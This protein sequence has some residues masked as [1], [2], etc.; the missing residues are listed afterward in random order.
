MRS[1][2]GDNVGVSKVVVSAIIGGSWGI[3]SV[4]SGMP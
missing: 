1:A 2:A 4:V 3:G